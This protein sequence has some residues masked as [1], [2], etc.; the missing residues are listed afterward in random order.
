M[1][2]KTKKA[3]PYISTAR[4][5]K[6]PGKTVAVGGTQIIKAKGRKP[7]TFTKG[8][9][10]EALNVPQGEKISA[11]KMQAALAGKYGAKAKKQALFAK[12]VLAKGQRTAKRGKK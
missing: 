7:L 12:N 2:R 5:K 1:A 10:H 8:G 4:A 9:L 6:M 3:G 11:S